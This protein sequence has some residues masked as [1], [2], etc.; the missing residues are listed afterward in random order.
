MFPQTKINSNVVPDPNPIPALTCPD[1]PELSGAR[2]L[3]RSRH[4]SIHSLSYGFTSGILG[5]CP[6]RR[7]RTP[8]RAD[9]SDRCI[10]LPRSVGPP[11]RRIGT[12]HRDGAPPAASMQS[13]PPPPRVHV[14]NRKAHGRAGAAEH[15]DVRKTASRRFC[16]SSPTFNRI[17]PAS[18]SE[19][20][21]QYVG[22]LIQ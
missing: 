8:H 14:Q 22:W 16:Q 21:V 11:E 13:C 1:T 2:S 15:M 4:G 19:I 12:P 6:K 5:N 20:L 3:R 17:C 9:T 7:I 18:K 10:A